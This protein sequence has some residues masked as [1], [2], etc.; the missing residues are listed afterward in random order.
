MKFKFYWIPAWLP[1][2][3]SDMKY[4]DRESHN[5]C[6]DRKHKMVWQ[7]WWKWPYFFK[8]DIWKYQAQCWPRVCCWLMD[9]CLHPDT[10]SISS[11]SCL[12]VSSSASVLKSPETI[13]CVVFP[14]LNPWHISGAVVALNYLEIY[15]FIRRIV[16]IDS[17]K[18]ICTKELLKSLDEYCE[19][20]IVCDCDIFSDISY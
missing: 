18:V 4:Y 9:F 6:W 7:W 13:A 8:M 17:F 20:N 1:T 5:I 12:L 14:S 16:F 3:T 2:I 10:V 19:K 11:V 15:T